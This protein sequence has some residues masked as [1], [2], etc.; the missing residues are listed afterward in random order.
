MQATASNSVTQTKESTLKL[1]RSFLPIDEYAKAKGVTNSVIQECASLGLIQLRTCRGKTFVI[2][3]P[4]NANNFTEKIKS[5][6]NTEPVRDIGAEIPILREEPAAEPAPEYQELKPL[7]LST[8]RIAIGLATAGFIFLLIASNCLYIE[9][10]IRSDLNNVMIASAGS[11]HKSL[12]GAQKQVKSFQ[13]E[14]QDYSTKLKYAN[15]QVESYK[16][17]VERLQTV[18]SLTREHLTDIQ[19]NTSD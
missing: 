3:L 17:E 9:Q 4:N 14:I 12:I 11:A 5:L 18:L 15:D 8:R 16:Q 19:T 10:E 2:E 13:A 7:L 1:R 6:N